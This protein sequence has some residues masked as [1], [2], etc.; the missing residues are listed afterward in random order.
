MERDKVLRIVRHATDGRDER[1]V[2]GDGH[3]YP[4]GRAAGIVLGTAV[5]AGGITGVQIKRAIGVD[6]GIL[7]ISV[8]RVVGVILERLGAPEIRRDVFYALTVGEGQLKR[9]PG[10]ADG[11]VEP[12]AFGVVPILVCRSGILMPVEIVVSREV[13]RDGIVNRDA[14]RRAPGLVADGPQARSVL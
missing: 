8:L 5:K 9:A 7:P 10:A 14:G 4:V 6:A 2:K 12:A 3:Q 1:V 11:D 13:A